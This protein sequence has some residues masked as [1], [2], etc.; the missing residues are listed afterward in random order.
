VTSAPLAGLSVVVPAYQEAERIVA[1]AEAILAFARE[2]GCD[3]EVLVCD[4]GS[5]DGTRERVDGAALPS[6]RVLTA[7]HAGKGAAVR[8]GVLAARREWILVTD[9]DLSVPLAEL[10]ALAARSG[11]A[12]IVI[13]SKHVPGSRAAYPRLRRLGSALGR[14]VIAACVVRGFRDTQCG[15]KLFRRDVARALFSTQRLDGF[16]FD[17][18]VLFLARRFGFPVAEVPV[19]VVHRHGGGVRLGSYLRTLGEVLRLLGHRLRGRYPKSPP[20][21]PEPPRE[22]PR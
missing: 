4:D 9:A 18:E 19:A 11:A 13:G 15:F 3:V 1:T 6:V 21:V 20:V 5:T 2:R 22:Q 10:D 17:F 8:R 12:P 14:C 16:G 7:P